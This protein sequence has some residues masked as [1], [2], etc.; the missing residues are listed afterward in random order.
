MPSVS[1]N[2][3]ILNVLISSIDFDVQEGRIIQ[4]SDEQID[5]L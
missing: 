4:I 2:E 3:E 1:P 5:G